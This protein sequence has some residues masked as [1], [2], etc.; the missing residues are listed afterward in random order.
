MNSIP[1]LGIGKKQKRLSTIAGVVPSLFNLPRGCLFNERC[2]AVRKECSGTAP[3][4]IDLGGGHIV[5]CH[6]YA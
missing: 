2:T 4:M 3:P 6:L 5:R 1:V